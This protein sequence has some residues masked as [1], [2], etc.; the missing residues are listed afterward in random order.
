MSHFL[1]PFNWSS[2]PDIG[3]DLVANVW[4]RRPRGYCCQT[5]SQV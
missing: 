3:Q 2:C 5:W 1:I 4:T